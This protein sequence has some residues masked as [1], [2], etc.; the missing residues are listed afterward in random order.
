MGIG[1]ERPYGEKLCVRESCGYRHHWILGG[2]SFPGKQLLC[3]ALLSCSWY[4]STPVQ[5]VCCLFPN[6]S[7]LSFTEQAGMG[8]R[9][10]H[11]ALHAEEFVT[12]SEP[13]SFRVPVKCSY[14]HRSA[15]AKLP[16]KY[17]QH[18]AW[19]QCFI[20]F[21]CYYKDSCLFSCVPYRGVKK[22]C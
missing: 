12:S 10:Q 22:R 13:S 1:W 15:I 4:F 18:P 2:S 5:A 6:S 9:L 17:F 8:K 19:F 3:S 16:S 14:W 11:Q 20:L 21:Q 7:P